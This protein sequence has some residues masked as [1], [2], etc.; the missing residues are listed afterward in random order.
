MHKKELFQAMAGGVLSALLF[1]LAAASGLG[2]FCLFLPTLPL[3]WLGL[4][5]SPKLALHGG[6]VAALLIAA[7]EL[8]AGVM[9]LFL[10]GLPAWYITQKSLLSRDYTGGRTWF[11]LGLIFTTLTWFAVALMAVTG[12]FYAGEPGGLPAILAQHMQQSLSEVGNEY[13][14]AVT[15]LAGE[16]SFLVFSLG[17]WLWALMIYGHGWL[18]NYLLARTG[19]N[20]RP[21][22]AIE[23]FPMPGTMLWLLAFAALSSLFGSE[24]LA[25][26]G[27]SGLIMLLFPYFLLGTALMHLHTKTWPSRR[28]FLFFV[29]AMIFVQ[30]WPA[31]ILCGMGF[32]HQIKCLSGAGISSK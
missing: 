17:V 14:E 28:F 11:P 23:V 21:D 10:L 6:I 25:F 26:L 18:A 27:K 15:I 12:L 19:R 16:L 5:T 7:L 3:F 2:F 22:F 24:S 32:F 29:Y 1:L 9:F 30:F 13:K 8:A 4:S 20:I 31:L